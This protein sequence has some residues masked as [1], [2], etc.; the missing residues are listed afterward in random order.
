MSGISA[1]TTS[2]KYVYVWKNENGIKPEG[3]RPLERPWH[4]LEGISIQDLGFEDV[5]CIQLPQDKGPMADCYVP[6]NELF[7]SIKLRNF[8]AF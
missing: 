1:P 2:L 7:D 3:K 4:R 5:G 6:G 8:M